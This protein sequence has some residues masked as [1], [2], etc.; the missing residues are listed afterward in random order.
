M[1]GNLP[2]CN[3]KRLAMKRWIEFKKNKSD[4]QKNSDEGDDSEHFEIDIL[5]VFRFKC[6]RFTEKAIIALALVLLFTWLITR[7]PTY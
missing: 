7:W 1:K 5:K 3:K 2:E 4:V 6:K